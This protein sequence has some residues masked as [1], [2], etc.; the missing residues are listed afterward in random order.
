MHAFVLRLFLTPDPRKTRQGRRRGRVGPSLAR[1]SVQ[2]ERAPNSSEDRSFQELKGWVGVVELY[3]IPLTANAPPPCSSTS[4]VPRAAAVSI[5]PFQSGAKRVLASP[6]ASI[7]FDLFFK[8]FPFA[9][10]LPCAD[11][12]ILFDLFFVDEFF[13]SLCGKPRCFI[14]EQLLANVCLLPPFSPLAQ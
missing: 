10:P 11:S 8:V 9:L 1:G 2:A 13:V 12:L 14:Y 6:T 5:R 4:N 7:T 3:C